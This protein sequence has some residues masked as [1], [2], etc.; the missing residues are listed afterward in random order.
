MRLDGQPAGAS[1]RQEHHP[2]VGPLGAGWE[3]APPSSAAVGP[4]LTR[5]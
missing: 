3:A 2:V 4:G 5:S 1:A